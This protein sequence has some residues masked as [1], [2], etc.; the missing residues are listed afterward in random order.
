[1]INVYNFSNRL[2]VTV[3]FKLLTAEHNGVH[4][5]TPWLYD[6]LRTLASIKTDVHAS[7][8]SAICTKKFKNK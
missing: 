2:D 5:L 1:V 4:V 8:L 7:L 6:P 3:A